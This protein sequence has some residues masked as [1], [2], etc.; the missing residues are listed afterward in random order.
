VT[1]RIETDASSLAYCSEHGLTPG[2]KATVVA[3]SPD[4]TLTVSLDP[5]GGVAETLALGLGMSRQ[6]YVAVD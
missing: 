1:E 6:I 4:G 3:K 5:L 2:R